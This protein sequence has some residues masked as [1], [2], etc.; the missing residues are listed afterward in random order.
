MGVEL[1][2]PTGFH[3]GLVQGFRYFT[4]K[5]SAAQSLYTHARERACMFA[6]EHTRTDTQHAMYL[7]IR[8]NKG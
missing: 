5:R 1:D 3:D 8:R 2:K 6:R 7:R 4:C